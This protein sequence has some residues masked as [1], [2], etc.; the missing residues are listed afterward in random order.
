MPERGGPAARAP[1]PRGEGAGPR[2][3]GVF[4][5]AGVGRL[6]P[7]TIDPGGSHVRGAG[8]GPSNGRRPPPA[9]P[10]SQH[11]ARSRRRCGARGRNAGRLGAWT[12]G[13]L[14]AEGGGC[15]EFGLPVLSRG[16]GLDPAWGRGPDSRVLSQHGERWAR[17]SRA[18]P[19]GSLRGAGR[20]S[21]RLAHVSRRSG[22]GGLGA[23]TSGS[24]GLGGGRAVELG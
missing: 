7:A 10:S 21:E 6:G 5:H 1:C 2:P 15:W 24:Q 8:P 22:P 11:S 14:S 4:E 18:R 13:A 17:R 19:P 9:P 23:R 12:P 16:G 3:R 20:G